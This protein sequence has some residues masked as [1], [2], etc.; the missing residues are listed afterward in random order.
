MRNKTGGYKALRGVFMIVLGLSVAIVLA[1]GTKR[2]KTFTT[3]NVTNNADSGPGSLRQAILD[4]NANPGADTITFA[5][6]V[7][8]TITLT[9]G[10]LPTT[11]ED[12]TITGPGT[13]SLTISGNH[14]SRVFEIALGVNVTI[15][16]LTISNG[17][18]IGSGGGICN[19]GKLMV[20]N[21]ILLGNSA[22]GFG[23]GIFNDGTGG[24]GATLTVIN[25]TLSSNFDG[26]IFN[27]FGTITIIDSTVSN[28]FSGLGGGV[29]NNGGTM[30]ITNSTLS[31]NFAQLGGGVFN[32]GPAKITNCTL[33]GNS[34]PSF[35]G[36][37]GI[38]HN[39]DTLTITNSTLSNNSAQDGAGF[40]NNGG[41]V[42]FKNSIIANNL[43]GV[44][45]AA[46]LFNASGI[47]F[48]TDGSCPG[49]TQVT[50]AQLN[51]GPLQDNGGPTMT[52]AL[53]PGSV[54]IDA[55]IDCT[56]IN[57]APVT[58]DQRGVR[59]PQDGN[60]D[61]VSRCDVG[62]YEAAALVSF[63]LCIQDDSNGSIFKIN[64]STGNYEFTNCSGL[65][66]RGIGSLV[67]KGGVITLKHYAADRRVLA[68][69]DSSVNKGTASIQILGQG[70]IFTLIDR[71]ISNNT[72]ACTVR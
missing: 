53:L 49:F 14:A 54:A 1:S 44:G 45:C 13:S 22:T 17:S 55:V 26:G 70:T 20:T 65:T 2:A 10:Q 35:G 11:T 51:L 5:A 38:W 32:A 52:H 41:T 21:S 16:D 15:S 29:S 27:S 68:K 72:C 9:T 31:D 47:N 30:T 66:L 12:L 28:N 57:G 48:S 64:V 42:N 8:G 23:G 36:G 59:R 69:I 7:T 33:S 56:D 62:A 63:D 19:A 43:S 24:S 58:T 34:A 50:P 60:G 3:F 71:N 6:T 39:A 18:L 61:G 25:S 37:G 40:R 46:L 67:V 4:A